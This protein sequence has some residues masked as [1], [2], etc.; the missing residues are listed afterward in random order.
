M[1]R[2]PRP[3][4]AFHRPRPA[5]RAVGDTEVLHVRGEVD[6]LTVQQVCARIEALAESH[7]TLAI[8]LSGAWLYDR[9]ALDALA[10][11]RK[12]ASRTGCDLIF[13]LAPERRLAHAATRSRNRHRLM[14]RAWTKRERT[15]STSAA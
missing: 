9:F 7:R 6:F 1:P 2:T 4:A 11:A 3:R 10:R 15:P 13:T 12:R 5:T 14:Q 8:D